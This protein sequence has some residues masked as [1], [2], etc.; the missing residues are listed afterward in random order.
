MCVCVCVVGVRIRNGAWLATTECLFDVYL[1]VRTLRADDLTRSF[2]VVT[3]CVTANG[4]V[5]VSLVTMVVV[6]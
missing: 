1:S 4:G 2:V 5:D 6:L 3:V